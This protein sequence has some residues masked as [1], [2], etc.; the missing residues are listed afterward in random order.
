MT[1]IASAC[2]LLAQRD[3][4]RRHDRLCLNMH[5]NLSKKYG[6]IVEERAYQHKPEVVIQN[7]S[8]RI[9]LD[10]M[11]QCNR[12]MEYRRPDIGIIEKQSNKCFTIDVANAGDHN[13]VKR[14]VG[15][16]E[17]YAQ[18]RVEIARM[19]IKETVVISVII[20]D[21]GSIPKDLHKVMSKLEVE[22]ELDT[23]QHS[24]L[25]GTANILRKVF[26]M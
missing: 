19:C 1:R 2:K 11:I 5:W 23:L 4:K 9:L 24:V 20:G 7:E 25:Q 17:K 22:Y 15:K 21:P 18:L 8:V 26:A 3:Y 13:I 10:F 12:E 14:K 6:L 16:F